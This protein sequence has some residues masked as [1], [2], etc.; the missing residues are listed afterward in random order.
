MAGVNLDEY[1]QK[2]L[3]KKQ[4]EYQKAEH[5]V[6][7]DPS[8]VHSG[9]WL[10]GVVIV[11]ERLLDV[12]VRR[13]LALVRLH[14][15]R[16]QL[17][18]GEVEAAHGA[19]VH[20][21]ACVCLQVA[22]HG[23]AAAEEAQA[24]LALVRL[25][26][27]VDAQVIRELTRVGEALPAETAAV[28]LPPGGRPPAST[29]VHPCSAIGHEP[30]GKVG[31]RPGLK[32]LVGKAEA[33]SKTKAQATE[34][35]QAA[36]VQGGR[37]GARGGRVV[38][39]LV[40]FTLPDWSPTTNPAATPTMATNGITTVEAEVVVEGRGRVEGLGAQEAAE[41]LLSDGVRC[42]AFAPG[43]STTSRT[44][45]GGMRGHVPVQQVALQEAAGTVRAGVDG[46]R[47]VVE[48]VPQK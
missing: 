45:L 4:Q 34:L 47:E 6:P 26:P 31:R 19:A 48:G 7:L 10:L 3:F 29:V 12:E 37:G 41:L 23:G 17:Q 8:G 1:T 22:D 27:C 36:R 2:K 44:H 9:Q 21:R 33:H 38:Q 13:K 25:L 40:R 20:Q 46:Q 39:S 30:R 24:H 32:Q 18:G 5:P 28:P 16:H 14:V 15:R 11:H 35:P 43:A 42:P